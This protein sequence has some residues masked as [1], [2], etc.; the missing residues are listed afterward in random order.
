MKFFCS[1]L[2]ILVFCACSHADEFLGAPVM[3]GGQLIR[4]TDSY[5]EKEYP[6][7]YKDMI[8]YYEEAFKTIPDIKYRNYRKATAIADLGK[9]PWDSIEISVVDAGRTK[10]VISKNRW[11]WV[12]K[13]LVFPFVGV[14]VVL[15]VLYLA[16]LVSGAIFSRTA[17]KR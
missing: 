4:K 2:F 14:F 15:S 3:N 9:Q 5:L 6:K 1:I 7:T 12:I 11:I 13:N 17:N 8:S 16:T 10:V